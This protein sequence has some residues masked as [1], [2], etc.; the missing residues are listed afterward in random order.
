[1]APHSPPRA[2]SPPP[3]HH[4]HTRRSRPPPAA[5]AQPPRS[6]SSRG[7]QGDGIPAPP[8]RFSP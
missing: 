1:M 7:E 2:P 6:I 5:V 8:S 4:H 3:Q